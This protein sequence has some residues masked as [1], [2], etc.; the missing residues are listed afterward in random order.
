MVTDLVFQ[1][2][3]GYRLLE[4]ERSSLPGKDVIYRFLNHSRLANRFCDVQR[5][6]FF[7]FADE[8]RELDFK[9][10]LQQVVAFFLELSQ[11]K[12]K[13]EKSALMSQVQQWIAGLPSYT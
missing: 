11:I 1:Q 13:R 3:N 9:S 10:A 7:L 2:R 5:G 8:V 12:T 6:L 4:S